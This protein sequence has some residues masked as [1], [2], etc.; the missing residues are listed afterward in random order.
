MLKNADAINKIAAA[1]KA[2]NL[3]YAEFIK[4]DEAKFAKNVQ[5]AYNYNAANAGATEQG[6][7][8][9]T[10]KNVFASLFGSKPATP[11]DPS[12]I[13]PT[14]P[15]GNNVSESPLLNSLQTPVDKD[16]AGRSPA[17]I[18]EQ[19][20]RVLRTANSELASIKENTK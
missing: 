4:L 2:Q 15:T 5:N 11:V 6:G 14:T 7:L 9:Q 13:T 12:K 1:N 16:S 20:E 8:S 18:L 10:V 3:A 19:I 17:Q